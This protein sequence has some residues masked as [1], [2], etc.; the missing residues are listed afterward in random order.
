MLNEQTLEFGQAKLKAKNA[1]RFTS[2]KIGG[3]LGYIVEDELTGKFFQIGLSQYTFLSLLSG[4]RTVNDAL[5]RTATLLRKH[6]FDQQEVASLCK[7]AIESGLLETE[8]GTTGESRERV[9]ADAAMQKAT[10]WLNPIT[11]KIPLASPDGVITEANRFLGWLVSPLGALLW[12]MVVCYG[13]G[14][15]LIHS[16]RFLAG[17]SMS[18]SANDFVW[19]GLAWVLL[20]LVHE[21]AHGL[22]CKAY[23][24]RVSSC[25]MLLLLMIPLPYV[26]V[27]SS[28]GFEN[29]WHRILTSSA[30]MVCEIFV[31]AIASVVWVN[32]DPGPIQYHA[33]NLIIAATLHTLI[34]NANPLM[35]FDGYFILSDLVGIPNLSGHGKAYVKG[36]FKWLYFGAKPKPVEEVGPRAAVVRAYGFGTIVWFFMISIGLSLAASGLLEGV[37]LMVALAGIFLWFVMPVFQFAKYVLLGSKFE[38]PNRKWFAVAASITCLVAGAFLFGCP[39]PSVVSAPVVIDYKP[40]GVIRA[41]AEGFAKALHVVPGQVVAEGDLLVTLENHDLQAEY[42]SLRVDIEI[43][44]LRIKS[45]LSTGEIAS[46]QLEEESLLANEKRVG[47]LEKLLANLEVRATQAGHVIASDFDAKLGAYFRPGDE[48]LTIGDKDSI[49]ATALV[50]QEDIRWVNADDKLQVEILVW[51]DG[52]KGVVTGTLVRSNPRARDDLPHDAF[53]ASNGGPLAVVPRQQVEGDD[54]SEEESLMLTQPRVPIEIALQPEDQQRILAGQS[55]LLMI[56]GRQDVMAG[57]LVDRMMRFARKNN[58]RTHG[59]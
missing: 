47:E 13:F 11:L 21:M 30:G 41:R 45:L 36:V 50:K 15:L 48:L 19:F 42:A 44:K 43:S 31:A 24:G 12:L 49:Q 29:K 18:F 40:G 16:D 8:I 56:R 17:V 14:L 33:G 3:R 20:K 9:A 10:S 37:G 38:Q 51:G 35:R 59:L 53:A 52:D 26:D 7:W 32:V 6:A 28:W 54:G 5:E 25:G 34:F 2:R 27:T 57:Y 23:G 55:G 39:S 1:L 4:R 58:V 46:V 22:V